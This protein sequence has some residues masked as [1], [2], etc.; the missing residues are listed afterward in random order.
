MSNNL[1]IRFL[2][3]VYRFGVQYVDLDV[4]YGDI[5]RTD[6]AYVI[7]G[8][9]PTSYLSLK[10]RPDPVVVVGCNLTINLVVNATAFGYEQARAAAKPPLAVV[11]PI[12]PAPSPA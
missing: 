7:D 6:A 4:D 5:V 9:V 10:S 8:R 11:R 1:K 3:V 12:R 2:A